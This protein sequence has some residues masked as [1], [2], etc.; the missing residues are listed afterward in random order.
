MVIT[1]SS[2]IKYFGSQQTS[3]HNFAQVIY[4]L[5][6]GVVAE[7]LVVCVI[8]LFTTQCD[9][10]SKIPL[11]FT[12]S[13]SQHFPSM[14]DLSVVPLLF[15]FSYIAFMLGAARSR[16]RVLVGARKLYLFRNVHPVSVQW[17]PRFIPR[18][19][20]GWG[21]KLSLNSI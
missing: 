9:F 6:S 11:I 19:Y 1:Y 18:G 7:N 20:N 3:P 2:L 13:T 14:F 4:S 16:V 17:V 15:R 5:K 12:Y 21:M 10:S 8:V